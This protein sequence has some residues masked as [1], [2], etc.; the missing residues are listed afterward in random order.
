MTRRLVDVAQDVIITEDDCGTDRGF[1]VNELV[2][3]NDGSVIV[4]LYDRLV[5]RYAKRK[6]IN[7]NTGEIIVEHDEMITD[8]IATEIVELKKLKFAPS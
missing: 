4:P 1:V 5:G 8:E 3:S 2:N 7:P 6:V